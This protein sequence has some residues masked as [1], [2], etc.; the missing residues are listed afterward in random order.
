MPTQSKSGDT[1]WPN[2]VAMQMMTMPKMQFRFPSFKARVAAVAFVYAV[3][4][5][6]SGCVVG[7]IC[8]NFILLAAAGALAGAVSGLLIESRG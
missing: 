1:S 8:T 4:G 5:A 6:V 7:A 2:R 3:I